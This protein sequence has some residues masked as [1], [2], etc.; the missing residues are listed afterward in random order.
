S[1]DFALVSSS[2]VMLPLTVSIAP[3]L[4]RAPI[5]IAPF[6]VPTSSAV[7]PSP[8]RTEPLTDETSPTVRPASTRIAPFT[9]E[10]SSSAWA[11][12][13]RQISAAAKALFIV[14]SSLPSRGVWPV[15]TTPQRLCLFGRKER[16]K[17]C[18]EGSGLWQDGAS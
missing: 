14:L 10:T 13:D 18:T 15:T 9:L 4:E 11:A 17:G 3:T 1:M 7:T 2:N 16:G 6:T 8:R 5:W 12:R